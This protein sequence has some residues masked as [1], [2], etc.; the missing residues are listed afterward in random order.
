LFFVPVPATEG[1]K[2]PV[3]EFTPGPEYVPFRKFPFKLDSLALTV[4]IYPKQEVKVTV[5]ASVPLIMISVELAGFPVT[6]L[7]S[8]VMIHLTLS[9]FAGFISEGM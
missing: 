9:L 8:E 5:G 3:N 7:R 2:N 1:A 6:T 4:V